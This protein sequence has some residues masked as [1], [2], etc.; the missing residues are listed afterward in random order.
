LSDGAAGIYF[1]ESAKV[2][3][4]TTKQTRELT[5]FLSILYD[6]LADEGKDPITAILEIRFNIIDLPH[7]TKDQYKRLMTN[8][9]VEDSKDLN[10]IIKRFQ[11]YG[12]ITIEDD[13][14]LFKQSVSRFTKMFA[15]YNETEKGASFSDE[16]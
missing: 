2:G 10:R 5:L 8:V 11:K 16:Y 15:E 13:T 4:T 3:S 7:L 14:I 9:G 1:F 12:F 6:H